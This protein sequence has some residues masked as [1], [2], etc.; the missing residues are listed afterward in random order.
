[1]STRQDATIRTDHDKKISG[2]QSNQCH[3]CS[4]KGSLSSYRSCLV[5]RA[6]RMPPE[7]Y[8]I[9]K[10]PRS[11]SPEILSHNFHQGSELPEKQCSTTHTD[12][13]FCEC[14]GQAVPTDIWE[15]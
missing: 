1:M 5:I 12:Q 6:K 7:K 2:N 13:Q 9:A 4:I 11:P 8:T 3:Q 10:R 14:A 15:E